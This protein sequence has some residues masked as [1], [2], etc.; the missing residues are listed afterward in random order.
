MLH[1]QFG[2][3]MRDGIKANRLAKP[4][5]LPQTGIWT[6]IKLNSLFLVASWPIGL[7]KFRPAPR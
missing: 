5:T 6:A 4:A 2:V 1:G 7:S 3:V